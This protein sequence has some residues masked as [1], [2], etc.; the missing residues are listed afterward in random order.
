MSKLSTELTVPQQCLDSLFPLMAIICVCLCECVKAGESER[1][2]E[3][4][5]LGVLK[6][7][8]ANFVIAEDVYGEAAAGV[9]T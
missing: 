4:V 6:K 1:G 3:K 5:K 7:V 2:H 9:D 8:R